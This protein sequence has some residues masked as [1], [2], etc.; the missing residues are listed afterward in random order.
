MVISVL[1]AGPLTVEKPK[2]PSSAESA[3][4]TFHSIVRKPEFFRRGARRFLIGK[5]GGDT[6]MHVLCD[7]SIPYVV[8]PALA[9]A[10][11]ERQLTVVR[12]EAP[13]QGLNLCF[14]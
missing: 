4:D 5:P 13:L 10:K 6:I 1:A 14:G 8:G 12:R 9:A 11:L 2:L 3:L 7:G